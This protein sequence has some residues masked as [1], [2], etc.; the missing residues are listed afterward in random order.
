MSH[1]D[2]KVRAAYWKKYYQKNRSRLLPI[3]KQ[4]SRIWGQKPE[5]KVR[6][7][8]RDR[9]RRRSGD[10]RNASYLREWRLRLRRFVLNRLGGRCKCCGEREFEFLVLDHVQGGG[11]KEN[12]IYRGGG[13]L[14]S[15]VK[16]DGC[17]R[18]KYQVLCLNCNWSKHIGGGV[19]VHKRKKGDGNEVVSEIQR[20]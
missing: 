12:K 6:R 4:R 20:H 3:M 17:P 9:E 5:N 15:K 18:K 13:V 19:C 1:K 16:K 14:L 11:T 7:N 8:E 10:C 2:L